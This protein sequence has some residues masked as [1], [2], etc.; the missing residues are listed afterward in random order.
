MSFI[1]VF[2]LGAIAGVVG[3]YFFHNPEKREELAALFRK[4]P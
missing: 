4:K 1:F 2:A 3:S